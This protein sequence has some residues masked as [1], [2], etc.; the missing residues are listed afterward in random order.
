MDDIEWDSFIEIPDIFSDTNFL[1]PFD[2]EDSDSIIDI[3][4]CSL[5]S[6]QINNDIVVNT[7]LSMFTEHNNNHLLFSKYGDNPTPLF[8]DENTSSSL[9]GNDNNPSNIDAF[10]YQHNLRV[11]NEFDD[12][13]SVDRFI[14]NY[15]LERGFGYQVFHNDKD[16]NDPSITRR[17][18]F[19][20]SSSGTYESWKAI[21][22]NSHH[23]R[24]PQKRIVDGIAPLHFQKLRIL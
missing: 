5:Y 8:E 22:Q 14:Y 12:W 21:D 16:S 20:C 24:V 15:C 18:S 13:P 10:S 9:F 1:P 6:N 17:K 19:R 7:D 11:R 23:I 2:N 3:N 4:P